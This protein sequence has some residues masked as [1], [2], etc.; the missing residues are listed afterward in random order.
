MVTNAWE[1]TYAGEEC[2]PIHTTQ[3]TLQL[4]GSYT[5]KNSSCKS[6]RSGEARGEWVHD[7][8]TNYHSKKKKKRNKQKN[9]L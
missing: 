5:N 1:N 6:D 2:S 7:D 9:T 3:T 8:L 4:T